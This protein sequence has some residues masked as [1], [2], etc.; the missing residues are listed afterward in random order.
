MES[1]K[2]VGLICQRCAGEHFEQSSMDRR[3]V[4]PV[5]ILLTYDLWGEAITVPVF[6]RDWALRSWLRAQPISCPA[7]LVPRFCP[8]M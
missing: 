3:S 4:N 6:W 1:P 8:S 2:E 5:Y 7:S